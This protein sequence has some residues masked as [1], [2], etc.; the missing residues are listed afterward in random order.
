VAE[1]AVVLPDE[2]QIA[3]ER[4][5]VIIGRNGSGKTRLARRLGERTPAPLEFI[6]ALRATRLSAQLP[7]MSK[8][9]AVQQ[10]DSY[11]T[12]ARNQPRSH[13]R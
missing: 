7:A 9:Q 1:I 11:K 13:R 4:P 5:I 12:N 10:H 8:I 6:N 3:G 2:S